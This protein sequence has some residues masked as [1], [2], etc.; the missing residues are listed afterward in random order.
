MLTEPPLPVVAVP[1]PIE[2]EPVEDD[3]DVPELKTRRPLA[4]FVPALDERIAT[5]PLVVDTP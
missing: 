5:T 4:P 3:E 1:V 2:M